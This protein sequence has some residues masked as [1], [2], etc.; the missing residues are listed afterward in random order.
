MYVCVG[1]A[2]VQRHSWE[3]P[4]AAPSHELTS[5]HGRVGKGV[6]RRHKAQHHNVARIGFGCT[7]QRIGAMQAIQD[8]Q[9]T[10]AIVKSER[11]QIIKLKQTLS[12]KSSKNIL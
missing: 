5:L 11:N 7:E 4:V 3:G 2:R 9:D 10:E 1:R 12:R 6:T 8:A